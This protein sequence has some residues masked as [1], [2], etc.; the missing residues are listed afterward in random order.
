[1]GTASTLGVDASYPFLR[2]SDANLS[3]KLSYEQKRLRDE[4]Q[5]IGRSNPK[6]ND[7]GEVAVSFDRRDG[8]GGATA[9][10]LTASLGSLKILSDELRAEDVLKTARSYG[11][12][13]A[14]LVRQQSLSGPFSLYLRA[15]GQASGGNL[16]S[17]EK[18][19]L[20]GPG[21][22]R[23]YAPGVAS[24]DQG[25][26]ISAE[27]RYAQ[28]YAG[29]GFLWGLFYDQAE[30]LVNRRPIVSA[31]NSVRVA[32][33][34]L[35]VQWSGGDLALSASLAFRSRP[36]LGSDADTQPRLYLQ[37]MITP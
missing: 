19:G 25:A 32:G 29:G 34:G 33:S 5:L 1:V 4:V 26:L 21:M 6:R 20:S 22:V 13:S 30:G 27:L 11:K 10:S 16:D 3:V 37:L 15:S 31:G 18:L 17:S 35:S 8:W 24:V 14:Q 12:A 7:V 9:G 28:P 23:A 2:T 36:A